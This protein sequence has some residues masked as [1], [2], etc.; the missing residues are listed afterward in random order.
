VISVIVPAWN[1]AR[2]LPDQLSA[3]AGQRYRGEWE[4]VVADNGS[5]DATLA[6]LTSWRD[7]FPSLRVVDASA[8]AGPA[9]ARN[10]GAEHAAGEVLAFTDADD[11]VAPSWLGAAARLDDGEQA[12]RDQ[13]DRD[14]FVTGPLVRFLDG[15]PPPVLS[16]AG[17]ARAPVHLGFLPY[18]GGTNFIVDRAA[19]EREGGFDER[20]RTGEDVDLSWRLQ[21][22]GISLRP[23]PEAQVA[24]RCRDDARSVLRQYYRYG[25]DD[26]VLYREFRDRG[27]PRQPF[28][29]AARSYLGLVARLPLLRRP[30]EREAW[31]HQLGRRSGRLIGSVRARTLLL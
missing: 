6:V 1:A 10:I 30:D 19:F 16:P 7:R 8:R 27:V 21:L 25:H 13:A 9:A 3:L 18:A 11:V 2:F 4:L 31:L 22:A 5:S 12:D 15:T 23:V 28:G 14:R 29:P 26:V 24:V 17:S 20:R